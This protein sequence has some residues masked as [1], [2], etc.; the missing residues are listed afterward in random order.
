MRVM[1][2]IRQEEPERLVYF[3]FVSKALTKLT[4]QSESFNLT[5]VPDPTK[6]VKEH[7]SSDILTYE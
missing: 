2:V 6:N 1:S 4:A 3:L 7:G 5:P